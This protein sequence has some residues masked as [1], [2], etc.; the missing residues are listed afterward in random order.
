MEG[1]L[2]MN[3]NKQ[4]FKGSVLSGVLRLTKTINGKVSQTKIDWKDSFRGPFAVEQSLIRK[5][6]Q[7]RERRQLKYFD[8][9]M[10]RMIDG[11]VEADEFISTPTMLG[12]TRNLLEVRN[13][14]LVGDSGLK[15]LVW[16]D[17]N[18]DNY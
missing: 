3:D 1:S 16:V 14:A 4:S 7:E 6:I 12:G 2:E 9:I 15:S 11:L 10:V 8:P 17:S 5:P 13:T 18:D